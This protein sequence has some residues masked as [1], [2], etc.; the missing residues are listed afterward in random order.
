[1]ALYEITYRIIPPG[2]GPDDYEPADLERRTERFELPDPESKTLPNG[3][4]IDFGPPMPLIH[5][6][7]KERLPEGSKV[8]VSRM[9]LVTD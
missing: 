1:M 5:A 3:T 7:I 2:V 9:D 8:S 4:P 6:V